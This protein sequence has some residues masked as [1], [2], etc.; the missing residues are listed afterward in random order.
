MCLELTLKAS[1][2]PFVAKRDIKCMKVMIKITDENGKVRY[3]SVFIDTD[4]QYHIGEVASVKGVE[5][6]GPSY[7]KRIEYGLHSFRTNVLGWKRLAIWIEE[8]RYLFIDSHG[9]NFEAVVFECVIP[10]GSKYFKGNSNTV[11]GD[12]EEVGY[13]SDQLLPVKEVPRSE[14]EWYTESE[15]AR[16][17]NQ[18]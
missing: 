1:R 18:K 10:K 13:A 6:K 15:C 2:K 11:I 9:K 16:V 7:R 14:W 5:C 8:N 12:E 4:F 17:V 3:H